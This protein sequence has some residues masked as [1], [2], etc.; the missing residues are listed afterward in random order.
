MASPEPPPA[1][2]KADAP[3]EPQN[4]LTEQ[5]TQAEWTALREMRNNLPKLIED[6]F[7][8]KEAPVVWGVPIEIGKGDAR[9]S[10]I[11][12][13][14][15]RARNLDVDEATKM[16]MATLKWREE[17]HAA[18][19]VNET[20]PEDVFGGLG[21]VFAKDKEGHPITWN[22]YGA[23]DTKKVFGDLDRFLRWRVALMERGIAQLDFINI[24]QMV[25]VHDYGGVGFSSRDPDS[26]RAATEA[27][28]LFSDNYPE[29]LSRKF[30][31]NVPAIFSWI[32]WLFK[33]IL[34][35]A[36]FA[37]MQ[38][39]GQGPQVIGK[40][41]LPIIDKAQLPTQY[42]GEAELK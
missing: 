4:P 27:S 28:K 13:K 37:K 40:E 2:I 29:L 35:A 9:V 39:V 14:F 26:K 24:D 32:F 12:V 7:P 23:V 31:I 10:V 21:Y 11:L 19:T 5:F 15:L 18:E 41:L 1:E 36:T 38:V 30:F 17:F 42:G 8:S 16:F 20:F 33:P 22:V 25:Q 34:P 6:T 3:T